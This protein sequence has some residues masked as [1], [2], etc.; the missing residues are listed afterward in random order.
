M[1]HRPLQLCTFFLIIMQYVEHYCFAL[2]L[3]PLISRHEWQQAGITAR[4]T[5]S[6]MGLLSLRGLQ[7]Q[8]TLV[9]DTNAPSGNA[10][11]APHWWCL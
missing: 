5:H 6:M 10:A 9:S 4:S 3:L 8:L 1:T 7:A 2:L 11:P